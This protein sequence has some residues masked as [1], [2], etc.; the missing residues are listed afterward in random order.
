MVVRIEKIKQKVVKKFNNNKQLS[1]IEFNEVI[2]KIIKNIFKN[3]E[4]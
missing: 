1:K 2:K 4:L 3:Y